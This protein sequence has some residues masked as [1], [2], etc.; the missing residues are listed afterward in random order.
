MS[1]LNWPVM[2]FG[3][4]LFFST[5]Y[6]GLSFIS[7]SIGLE[8]DRVLSHSNNF[9]CKTALGS[10]RQRGL[11]T[12]IWITQKSGVDE[13]NLKFKLEIILWVIPSSL[14]NSLRIQMIMIKKV[15]PI[16]YCPQHKHLYQR[17]I[18]NL[19]PRSNWIIISF[20]KKKNKRKR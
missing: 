20:K 17:I 19:I 14:K 4:L 11:L 13:I 1:T 18:S 9:V 15:H 16:M 6:K 5:L 7:I 10:R 12:V 3:L 8:E 2:W